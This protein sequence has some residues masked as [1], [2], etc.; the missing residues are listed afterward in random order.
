MQEL[1]K[2]RE[3]IYEDTKHMSPKE[4]A[5]LARKEAQEMIEIYGLKV[6]RLERS[7]DR[8]VD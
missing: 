8:S 2:I 5:A 6:K 3:R 7:P 1:Y 4:R